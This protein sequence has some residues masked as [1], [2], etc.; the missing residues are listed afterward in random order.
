MYSMLP[1]E[2]GNFYI[3]WLYT[4]FENHVV[5]LVTVNTR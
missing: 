4:A 1:L 2:I 3:P 5:T